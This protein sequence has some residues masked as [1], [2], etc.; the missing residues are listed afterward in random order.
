MS[1]PQRR[2]A[3]QYRLVRELAGGG[4]G[5]IWQAHDEHL[6]VDVAVKEVWFPPAID[7]AEH[8][9]RL[10]YAA[11]EARNAAKLRSHPH[12]VPVYSVVIEDD[13][14]WIVMELVR[15]G[16]LADR[17]AQG[18]LP[19]KDVADVAEA[20]LKALNA[21]H[22]ARVVHRDV[23]PANIML[24]DDG[25]ILLT[26]FGIAAHQDDTRLTTVGNVIGTP[27]YLA[28]ERINGAEAGPA[29]DLFALGVT[30]YRAAEGK[31]PFRRETDTAT[32]GAV[33]TQQPP[34]MK[35]ADG[36]ES[37][38]F[39]LLDKDPDRRLTAEAA[40]ERLRGWRTGQKPPDD[41]P[42][43]AV[44]TGKEPLDAYAEKLPNPRSSQTY[45]GWFGTRKFA[46]PEVRSGWVLHVG[47]KYIMTTDSTVRREFTWDRILYISI[48]EFRNW[49]PYQFTVLYLTFMPGSEPSLLKPAGWP[50]PKAPLSESVPGVPV[51][52]LGPMTPEQRAE[53]SEA[54]GR[55]GGRRWKPFARVA[56][57]F[58]TRIRGWRR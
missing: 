29:S 51:C 8:S 57:E 34:P 35:K 9:R 41:G 28:P 40:L 48:R 12:I 30:L 45:A 11:R 54:L 16:S 22:K 1:S 42:F 33:A 10:E 55:Y 39:G 36:L 47:P 18:S 20:M 32:L 27:E 15:G 19:P 46:V 6:D 38:V 26:D 52:V 56:N 3:D 31:S 14:P 24:A 17:L 43:E 23:K 4:F 13:R 2:I 37:L 7:P 49:G 21:A 58:I 53:L 25:R 44:W 5:R 50:Y